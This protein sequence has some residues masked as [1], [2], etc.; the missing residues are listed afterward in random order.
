MA[1]ETKILLQCLFKRANTV[2]GTVSI[3]RRKNGVGSEFI[4]SR[5]NQQ[6]SNKVVDPTPRCIV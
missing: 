4:L 1:A 3:V 2:G 6:L 5:P